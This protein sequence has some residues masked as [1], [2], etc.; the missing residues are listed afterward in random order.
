MSAIGQ[1]TVYTTDWLAKLRALMKDNDF[2][3]PSGS[4]PWQ[5]QVLPLRTLPLSLIKGDDS[6]RL[7]RHQSGPTDR[8]LPEDV[9]RPSLNSDGRS[10]QPRASVDDVGQRDYDKLKDEK[11]KE[12]SDKDIRQQFEWNNLCILY[13]IDVL[14]FPL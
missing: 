10:L 6:S 7:E 2:V 14:Y 13:Y 3:V 8:H 5:T 11:P 4:L 9:Q 12:G 1:H